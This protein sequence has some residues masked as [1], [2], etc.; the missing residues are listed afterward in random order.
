MYMVYI[1][2]PALRAPCTWV[3]H[4]GFRGAPYDKRLIPIA[5]AWLLLR[6]HDLYLDLRGHIVRHFHGHERGT[7][8]FDR[9]V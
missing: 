4:D 1:A 9:L 2:V 7:E 6:F 5:P 3:A 8:L